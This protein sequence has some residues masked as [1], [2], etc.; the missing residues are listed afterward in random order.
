MIITPDLYAKVSG[1]TSDKLLYEF[2]CEVCGKPFTA[3]R[4]DKRFCS[5]SCMSK[6]RYRRTLGRTRAYQ[7]Q[8]VSC[9]YCGELFNPKRIDARYCSDKCRRTGYYQLH[10][11]S[12]RER[13]RQWVANNPEKRKDVLERYAENHPDEGKERYARLKADPKRWGATQAQQH[14]HYVDNRE[15]YLERAKRRQLAQPTRHYNSRHGCDWDELFAGL[16]SAQGGKC[17]LCGDELQLEAYRAIHLDH[18]HSCCRLG[19]SCEICRR[20]LACKWCNT[21]VGY[22]KDDPARLRR[23]ADNLEKANALVQERMAKK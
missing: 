17:Y 1:M 20:G 7:R 6:E 14:Q 16:W 12:F 15:E 11:E 5:D 21:L 18:D 10:K 9:A 8:D 22:A 3:R 2:N 19:Y 23:V 13:S 4:R